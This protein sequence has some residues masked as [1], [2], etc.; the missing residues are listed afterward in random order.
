[1]ARTQRRTIL[2][3]I[4]AAGFAALVFAAVTL[5][6]NGGQPAVFSSEGA[7]PVGSPTVEES[8]GA[9]SE[10]LPLEERFATAPCW[11]E[12]I[13]TLEDP[14]AGDA[15]FAQS[16]AA[17]VAQLVEY[18][19]AEAARR[20][21]EAQDATNHREVREAEA[22]AAAERVVMLRRVQE[23]VT[24]EASDGRSGTSLWTAKNPSGEVTAY[25]RLVQHPGGGW[26][27]SESAVSLSEETCK[28]I[29]G[30]D[31]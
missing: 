15:T 9:S 25:V 5:S 18:A 28:A 30:T 24:H 12:E 17:A 4:G 22:A 16:P 27:V 1:M 26:A 7:D 20:Q 13:V 11:Q 19:S 21:A 6:L 2:A 8:V 10:P 23:E 14:T 31:P 3:L 29:R